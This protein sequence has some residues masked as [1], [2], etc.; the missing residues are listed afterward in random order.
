VAFGGYLKP[1]DRD[2]FGILLLPSDFMQALHKLKS[3]AAFPGNV[4]M[5]HQHIF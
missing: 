1:F 5:A 4:F 3:A 2:T